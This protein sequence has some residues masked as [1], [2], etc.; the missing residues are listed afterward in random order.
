MVGNQ[1][2]MPE[3]NN[4]NSF[5]NNKFI[6]TK[7]AVWPAVQYNAIKKSNDKITSQTAVSSY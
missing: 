7:M 3:S 5:N 6:F 1:Y 4:S 2:N